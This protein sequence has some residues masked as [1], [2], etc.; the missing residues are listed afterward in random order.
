LNGYPAQAK[1]SKRIIIVIL[2]LCVGSLFSILISSGDIFRPVYSTTTE[3]DNSNVPFVYYGYIKGIYIGLQRNPITTTHNALEFYDLFM[4]N[5]DE[6]YKEAFLNNSNWLVN[7]AVPHGKYSILE[8]VFPWPPYSLEPPWRS[9]MAQGQALQAL[10]KA[11]NIT[12]E[13][14]YLDTAKMLL[15]SFFVEV[16]DGGVT[17]KTPKNG[18][19]YEEYAGKGDDGPR[20]LNGMMFAVL[21]IYDYYNYT[22]DN[23]AKYLFDQ[24]VLSLKENLWRY[25]HNGTYSAYDIHRAYAP[26]WWHKTHV[27]LL[28]QLYDI[29]KEEIFKKYHDKWQN[30]KL[31]SHVRLKY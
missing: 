29:T 21:G 18:W 12:G 25:D 23:S 15:N 24:G 13:E 27:D 31:P 11:H 19:W 4:K 6:K 10:I 30:Y 1:Y 16:K 5:R 2:G 3:L 28:N 26:L 7:N 22:K 14:K 20:V 17:Y 8:Y 9:G